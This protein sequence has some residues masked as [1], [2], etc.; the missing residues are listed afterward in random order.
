MT[1]FQATIRLLVG[2]L[3]VIPS[4]EVL[5]NYITLVLG[6]YDSGVHMLVHHCSSIL[7]L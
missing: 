1:T 6:N 2:L 5:S 4:K 7:G 3:R